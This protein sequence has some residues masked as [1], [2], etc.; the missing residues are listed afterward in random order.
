QGICEEATVFVVVA[1]GTA[2]PCSVA[3]SPASAATEVIVAAG[4]SL[5]RMVPALLGARVPGR[6]LGRAWPGP[7]CCSSSQAP[8]QRAA[9]P[10]WA[11]VPRDRGGARAVARQLRHQPPAARIRSA[12]DSRSA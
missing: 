12:A 10:L 7:A 8:S 3:E 4:G 5:S 2:K 1:P 6:Q 9:A 11:A